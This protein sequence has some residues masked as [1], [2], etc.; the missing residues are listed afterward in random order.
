M[1]IIIL[2]L[3]NILNQD[4]NAQ[5]VNNNESYFNYTYD[6]NIIKINNIEKLVIGAFFKSDYI[7]KRAFYF[8]KIGLL[9]RADFFDKQGNLK[10][11]YEYILNKQK[12]LINVIHFDY[13]TKKSDTVFYFKKYLN[14]QIIQDSIKRESNFSETLDYTYD[15]KNYLTQIIFT[16]Y[17]NSIKSSF[18]IKS[19]QNNS[20]G[21]PEKIKETFFQNSKDSNKMI[22]SDR[23]IDYYKFGKI[24]SETEEIETSNLILQN[25]GSSTYFYDKLKN[26]IKIKRAK[27]K[28]IEYK[29]NP[30]GL[31]TNE[32]DTFKV[33]EDVIKMTYKFVYFMHSKLKFDNKKKK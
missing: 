25:Q 12:D 14:G 27:G 9:Y 33:D 20:L 2:V 26:L 18:K 6:R 8:N 30:S 15:K 21:K 22:I 24:N 3:L 7:G 28:T 19:F 13:E 10:N 5:K 31:L 29:Y 17:L 32:E 11:K 4:L 1:K 23:I 16:T